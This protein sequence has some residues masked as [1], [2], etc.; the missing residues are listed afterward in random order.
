MCVTRDTN[1]SEAVNSSNVCEQV[2]LRLFNEHKSAQEQL[3]RQ[4]VEFQKQLTTELAQQRN[5]IAKELA[6][7][8]KEMELRLNELVRDSTTTTATSAFA[9][10]RSDASVGDGQPDLHRG[11]LASADSAGT[12]TPPVGDVRASVVIASSDPRIASKRS[13]PGSSDTIGSRDQPQ[14]KQ[15]N[16]D[17][18]A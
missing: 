1:P 9:R 14:P 7:E 10:L 18:P 5:I 11:Q 4:Q 13:Q 15:A 3:Q 8:R 6:R 16:I 2:L 17:T 12:S